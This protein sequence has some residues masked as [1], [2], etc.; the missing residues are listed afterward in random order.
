MNGT[1]NQGHNKKEGPKPH[2]KSLHVKS[3]TRKKRPQKKGG[4]EEK[5]RGL[6]M[7]SHL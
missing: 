3:D 2:V 1:K 7:H 4:E 5:E 6:R